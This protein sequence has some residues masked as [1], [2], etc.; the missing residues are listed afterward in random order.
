[1]ILFNHWKKLSRTYFNG[2]IKTFQKV[3][4]IKILLAPTHN[5]EGNTVKI[6]NIE[7]KSSK[8]EHSSEGVL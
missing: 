5:N 6:N 4:L 1:M 2:L 3:I 7:I 8:Q